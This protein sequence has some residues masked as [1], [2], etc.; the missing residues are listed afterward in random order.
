MSRIHG[1]RRIHEVTEGHEEDPTRVQKEP[2]GH[3][4]TLE[5]TAPTRF[6][7]VIHT[8]A[9]GVACKQCPV[10]ARVGAEAIDKAPVS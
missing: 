6:G 4:R 5:D 7:T 2:R 10:I 3:H 8:S 1:T 9:P